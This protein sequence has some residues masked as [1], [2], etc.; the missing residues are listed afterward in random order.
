MRWLALSLLVAAG[1]AHQAPPLP[2][3]PSPG[4]S[5]APFS[6]VPWYF[7]NPPELRARAAPISPERQPVAGGRETATL[8]PRER[9]DR[10]RA[11]LAAADAEIVLVGPEQTADERQ[12]LS[13]TVNE[14]AEL[15]APYPDITAEANELR[16][17]VSKLS[18]TRAIDLPRVKRRMGQLVDL[19]RLQLFAGT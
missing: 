2:L 8:T 5:H 10:L 19:I 1:C 9:H 12:A 13:L 3:E 14:I 16:E 15:L 11:L 4:E 7:E 17:H 6:G 18:E